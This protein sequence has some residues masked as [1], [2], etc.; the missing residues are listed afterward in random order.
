MPPKRDWLRT[1]L[2]VLATEKVIQHIFVTAAFAFNWADMASTV[3]VN[4][5]V[6][7]VLGGMLGIAFAVSL[8]GMT[9]SRPWAVDLVLG[10]SVFDLVGEYVAQG[11][12][13]IVCTVS[14][15][16]AGCLIILSLV[17]RRRLKGKGNQPGG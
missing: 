1:A 6:L 15:L 11:T 7:L 9:R 8:W 12:L 2:I 10:L 4:P 5:R 13:S 17:Y 14:F 3:A 16:V